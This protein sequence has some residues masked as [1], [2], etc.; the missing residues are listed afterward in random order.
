MILGISQR[1]IGETQQI[2]FLS[3]AEEDSCSQAFFSSPKLPRPLTRACLPIKLE[4]LRLI[5]Y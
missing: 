1:M 4:L 3:K 2:P 5:L